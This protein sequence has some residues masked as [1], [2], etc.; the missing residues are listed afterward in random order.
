MFLLI[1]E[2]LRNKTD[3]RTNYWNAAGH[4]FQHRVWRTLAG[5]CADIYIDPV[6]K[7]RHF[8]VRDHAVQT[9]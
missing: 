8:I 2:K 1:S 7:T 9:I 4:G 6:I 3:I 5:R